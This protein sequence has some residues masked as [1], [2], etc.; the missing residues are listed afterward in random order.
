MI[1]SSTN[2]TAVG[3]AGPGA[4]DVRSELNRLLQSDQ[5]KNSKRCQTL[6]SH[7]VNEALAGHADQLKERLVGV[8]VFHR[9]PDYD[10][11]EDPVVR[12]AAIE[13]RKR[14]AQF[15]VES[16]RDT[17]VRIELHPG[18]YIP[19]FCFSS[20]SPQVIEPEAPPAKPKSKWPRPAMLYALGTTLL[21]SIGLAFAWHHFSGSA[22]SV[23]EGPKFSDQ[24]TASA[25][26][27]TGEDGAIRILAGNQQAGPY[28]D[29]FGNQW[30]A[31]RYFSGGACK[32]GLTNFFFPP[33]DPEL[34]RM[35]RRGSFTYD[36]PLKQNQTYEMRLY[37]VESQYRYGNKAAGDGENERLFQVRANGQIIL[38]SF[39]IVEDSS[40]ASTTVRAFKNIVAS[41]NGKLHLEFIG[42][43]GEP[44]LNAIE[45]LPTNGRS[46]PPI[47]IHMAPSNYTD[48]AG[49][50]WS[51]DN[52]YIG[53]QLFD[54]G[55]TLSDTADPL[56]FNGTR[57]GNFS[58]AIPV[59]PGRYSVTLYFAET[60][61]KKRGERV[62]DV[63]C[64]GV[65][66]FHQ[67]DIFREGGFSH[68]FSKTFHGLEPNGQGK[69]LLS[70]SPMVNYA[71]V[72][73]IEIV[74][75]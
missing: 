60:W 52:F 9:S 62:F 12:N 21:V 56:L 42:Q 61:F 72:S 15:Y 51:P 3:P 1:E 25:V 73:A 66:L 71:S 75:E 19:E 38:N 40:F 8:N 46:I 32:P 24:T 6:L 63:T 30:M 11:S 33:A 16:G 65:S 36:I 2:E 53:G 58:Y 29:R 48:H 22:V 49:N 43:R 20:P 41:Q 26:P 28:I 4:D 34:F 13:V 39:D 47:R 5:F 35:M 44:V 67:L 37:F 50:R 27:V 7:V 45:L 10:T 55:A 57:L 64:N 31:D 70:F 59:P 17:P 74:E 23:Q 14:L 54:S 18:T 69:L 68:G